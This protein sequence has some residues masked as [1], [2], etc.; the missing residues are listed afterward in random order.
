MIGG[1]CRTVGG[2]LTRETCNLIMEIRAHSHLSM[3]VFFFGE[4]RT[5]VHLP[6]HTHS[7]L[8]C[9]IP[10]CIRAPVEGRLVIGGGPTLLC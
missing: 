3:V 9:Q 2:G 10:S 6:G 7:Q 4:E 8:A 1:G 5:R